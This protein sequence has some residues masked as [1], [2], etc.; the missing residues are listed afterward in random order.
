M[1][2]VGKFAAGVGLIGAWVTRGLDYVKTIRF[3]GKAAPEV[4]KVVHTAEATTSLTASAVRV[5]RN[6][7]TIMSI[8]GRV[9]SRINLSN[10]GLEHTLSRHF[11]PVKAENKSQFTISE[12][13]LRSLLGAKS[14]IQTPA[15]A[16]ETG[17]FARTITADRTVGNLSEKMG[18]NSTNTFTGITDKYGDLQTT[19]PGGL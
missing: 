2:G 8:P 19:F 18:G 3:F 9:Q 4:A 5:E 12:T 15:R 10:K 6:L 16:L 7:N 11:N 14:T 13:E 17:N 1:V